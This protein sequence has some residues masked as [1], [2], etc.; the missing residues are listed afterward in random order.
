MQIDP[1][2][3]KKHE[4]NDKKGSKKT[5]NFAILMQKI[6]QKTTLFSQKMHA[7]PLKSSD[8]PKRQITLMHVTEQDYHK[9]RNL[10][11]TRIPERSTSR[12][13]KSFSSSLSPQKIKDFPET[14][15]KKP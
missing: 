14:Q 9:N 2:D 10:P 11:S 15:I 12:E 13:K 7:S 1:A 3:T 8:K 4:K 5:L 6:R